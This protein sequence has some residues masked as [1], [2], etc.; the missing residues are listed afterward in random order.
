M[1]R[2]GLLPFYV[3]VALVLF[4]IIRACVQNS[5]HAQTVEPLAAYEEKA[6]DK[7][8]S[9][10]V[11]EAAQNLVKV[12][13]QAHGLDTLVVIARRRY[14][15]RENGD[16]TAA[17]TAEIQKQ[18]DSLQD[19]YDV[20]LFAGLCCD[21]SQLSEGP[22]T[23]NY[24]YTRVFLDA[25]KLCCKRLSQNP[26]RAAGTALKRLIKEHYLGSDEREELLDLIAE[27]EKLARA[28]H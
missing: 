17:D 12:E 23:A 6:A 20:Y 24:A 13:R 10:Y 14:R 26:D 18:V 11:R 25:F 2:N 21:Y 22:G 16:P 19:G 5:Q 3:C 1:K 28:H 8:E 4:G 27:Q 9:V 15:N 7:R